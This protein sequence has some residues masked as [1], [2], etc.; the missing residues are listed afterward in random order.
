MCV[1]VCVCVCGQTLSMFAAFNFTWP[2]VVVDIF[3]V[4]SV[5]T[6]SPEMTAPGAC[7]CC[8]HSTRN[9]DVETPDARRCCARVPEC[10]LS[11]TYEE[12]WALMEL[13]PIGVSGLLLIGV[14]LSTTVELWKT[15]RA[16]CNIFAKMGDVLVGGR[17]Q[18]A[19]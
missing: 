14:A 19:M 2:Q 12:K 9:H 4:A 6:L 3:S 11:F 16:F 5:A 10:T 18:I 15:K 8:Q 17:F 1:C 7:L 13:F